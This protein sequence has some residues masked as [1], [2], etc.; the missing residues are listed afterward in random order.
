MALHVIT[1]DTDGS[2]AATEYT[3]DR[4]YGFIEAIQIDYAAGLDAGTDVTI[5]ENEHGQRTILTR[6]NTATDGVFYPAVQR[7]DSTG[8]A[9]AGAYDRV[10]VYGTQ[11]KAAVAQSSLNIASAITIRI[12]T[13]D[14]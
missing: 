2:G 12:L 7:H 11:L 9:I 6:S 1:I 4:V 3:A 5:S 10:Y 14:S 8:A 13:S